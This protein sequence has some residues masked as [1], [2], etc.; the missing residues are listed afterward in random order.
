MLVS[1]LGVALSLAFTG[2]ASAQTPFQATVSATQTLPAGPCANGA[3]FCGTANLAGYGSESWNFFVTSSTPVPS[4]CGSSYTAT[5]EFTLAGDPGSTLVLDES[6]AL[7][8][9]GKDGAA[10]FKEGSKAYGHPFTIV[11]SWSVDPTSTGQFA[12]LAG[13]GTDLVKTAGARAAGSYTGTL[14]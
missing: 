4:S 11:G 9:P 6:G 13:S 1:A 2:E 10:F 12:A 8:A 7:C 3:F 5:T 14:G